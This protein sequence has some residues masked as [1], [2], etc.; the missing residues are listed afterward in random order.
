MSIFL[1]NTKTLNAFQSRFIAIGGERCR[2]SETVHRCVTIP[3]RTGFNSILSKPSLYWHKWIFINHFSRNFVRHIRN[4]VP[5]LRKVDGGWF[6]R[7]YRTVYQLLARVLQLSS[8]E[9]PSRS[10]ELR[11]L[12]TA[13]VFPAVPARSASVADCFDVRFRPARGTRTPWNQHAKS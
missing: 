8:I 7:L 13:F 10:R 3:A 12:S 2:Y 11:K 4:L 6:A 1:R 5:R 9:S